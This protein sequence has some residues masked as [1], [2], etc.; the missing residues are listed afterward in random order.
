MA[1]SL[2]FGNGSTLITTDKY[3]QVRDL[4]FPYVG[5]ENHIGGHYRHKIGVWV[6]GQFSWTD[7]N[8]WI[9]DTR[10][11]GAYTGL[12][13]LFSS[14]LGIEL[15]FTDSLSNEKNIFLR[16]VKVQN[17]RD[18]EREIR[19]FFNH[20]YE[21]YHS[22]NL[23]TAF[24]DPMSNTVI[25][26]EGRRAF[27]MNALHDGKGFDDYTVGI[28]EIEGKEGTYRRSAKR[29]TFPLLACCR[30]FN[31][32]SEITESVCDTKQP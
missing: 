16:K 17:R 27:L 21:I 24:Y 7:D 2:A 18:G 29:G 14:R 1:K 5:L 12:T 8:T 28:F 19:V 30:P 6:D 13:S 25:H 15:H 11:D 23:D 20:Q 26:Y 10:S 22:E 9:V 4:Y 32:R 31:R 3:G